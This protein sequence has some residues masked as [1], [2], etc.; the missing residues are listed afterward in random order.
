MFFSD[1]IAAIAT[2]AGSGSIGVI[3]ISGPEA[4]NTIKLL[5]S[6]KIVDILDHTAVH[7]ILADPKTG[8][9]LDEVIYTAFRAPASYTGEDVVEISCHGSISVLR[10]VLGC[11]LSNGCR[12]AEPGEF[13]RRA[14]L[15]GKMDL[16]QAEAVN[17]LIRSRTDSSRRSAL[18]QLRGNLSKKLS[19]IDRR[20]LALMAAIEAS[21]DFP[22]DVDEPEIEWIADEIDICISQLSALESTFRGGKILREGASVVICG[23]VNVGKSSLL[24]ALLRHERAIVTPIP[25]TTRDLIEEGL[26][27]RGIPLTAIDTAGIRDT[28]DPVESVGLD[29]AMSSIGEADLVLLVMDAS[30]MPACGDIEAVIQVEPERCILVINKSDV[31]LEGSIEACRNIVKQHIGAGV[32][33][34]VL[35][36]ANETGIDILEDQ[37]YNKLTSGLN[38]E[39]V[40]VTNIRHHSAIVE[41]TSALE[42]VNEGIENNQPLDLLCIDIAESRRKIGLVTGETIGEDVLDSIFSQFCIG[43]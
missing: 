34:V 29:M 20:L 30:R 3:R 22:D 11:I 26:E 43:K 12:L 27:I 16:S 4:F 9:D 13:T 38:V 15:Y 6:K 2:P 25:G 36:A 21:I 41:S 1:T 33:S 8:E 35:S 32:Q 10:S 5:S 19:A 14:Y 39:N 7:A 23:S 37:I 24:N 18:R 42:R 17:D 31:A 28:D 40:L